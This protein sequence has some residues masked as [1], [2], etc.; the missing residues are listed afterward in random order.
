MTLI[1]KIYFLP[2]KLSIVLLNTNTL[3][4][5]CGILCRRHS[6]GKGLATQDH[7]DIYPTTHTHTHNTAHTHTGSNKMGVVQADI[8]LHLSRTRQ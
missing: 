4:V 7:I 3:E 5:S 1:F 6:I 2:L 8:L